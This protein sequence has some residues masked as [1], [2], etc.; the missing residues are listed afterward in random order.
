MPELFRIFETKT[1]ITDLDDD[2]SGHRN[3]IRKKLQCY[4]YPALRIQPYFGTNIKKL[5]NFKPPTWRYRIGDYR[6][7]YTIKA[8][9]KTV[10]MLKIS[11][12]ADAY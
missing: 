5:M 10:F 6:F 1:F 8:S 2:F 12:R 4:V 3:K 11:L 7:F 9:E